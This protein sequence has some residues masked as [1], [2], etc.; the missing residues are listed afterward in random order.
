MA[1]IATEF[2][3][4]NFS[5]LTRRDEGRIVERSA[6]AACDKLRELKLER[7]DLLQE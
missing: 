1:E 2:D 5:D 6:E 3:A 7:S 4:C